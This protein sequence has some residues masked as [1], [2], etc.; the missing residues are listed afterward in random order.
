MVA[1]LQTFSNAFS[2]NENVWISN[3]ISFNYVPEYLIDDSGSGL[4]LNIQ[5]YVIFKLTLVN[6]IWGISCEIALMWF[7]EE[8]I[9]K[10]ST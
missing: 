2:W 10:K 9:N 6:D 1:V 7:S 5:Q 8:L 4:A 3:K